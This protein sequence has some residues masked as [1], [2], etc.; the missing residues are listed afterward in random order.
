MA[1]RMVAA[2]IAGM[3]LAIPA[4]YGAS[5]SGG[6]A[7]AV[8]WQAAD[9]VALADDASRDRIVD[10]VQRKYNARVVKVTEI[11]VDGRRAYEL[12]LLSD[13]RV[14]MIRVDAETGQELRGG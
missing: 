12:R 14:W 11:V 5:S 7:A 10:A 4:S 8:Q 2:A 13:E 6:L 3:A 9:A 1:A